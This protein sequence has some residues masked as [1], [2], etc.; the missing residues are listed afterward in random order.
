VQGKR[1]HLIEIEM[2]VV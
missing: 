2:D 1:K